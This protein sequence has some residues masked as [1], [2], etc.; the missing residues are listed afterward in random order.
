MKTNK[1][2]FGSGSF[3]DEDFALTPYLFLVHSKATDSSCYGIGIAW[4]WW[5]V[6]TAVAI[7]VPVNTPRFIDM[8]KH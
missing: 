2:I 4:G 8:D 1:L 7:G 3:K 6:F 5:G